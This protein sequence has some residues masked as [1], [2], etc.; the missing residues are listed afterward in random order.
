MQLEFGNGNFSVVRGK[1]RGKTRRERESVKCAARGRG[2]GRGRT[3]L[4]RVS[5]PQGRLWNSRDPSR[6]FAKRRPPGLRR[7]SFP[8]PLLY[9]SPRFP[10]SRRRQ[11]PSPFFFLAIG[12]S[13]FFSCSRGFAIAVFFDQSTPRVLLASSEIVLLPHTLPPHPAFLHH[14]Y[15]YTRC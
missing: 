8:P 2:R 5:I 3:R 7:S 9:F 4:T 14:Y 11:C 1:S 12:H 15:Y 6:P 13:F 10:A